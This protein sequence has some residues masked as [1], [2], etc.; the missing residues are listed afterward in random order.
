MVEEAGKGGVGSVVMIMVFLELCCRDCK[1]DV[2][3]GYLFMGFL[4]GWKWI[5]MVVVSGWMMLRFL[6]GGVEISACFEDIDQGMDLIWIL[7]G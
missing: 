7:W 4:E 6:I 2:F 5:L 3:H 1:R